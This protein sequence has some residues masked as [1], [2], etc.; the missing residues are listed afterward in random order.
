MKV[1]AQL[2]ISGEGR[3]Q[4]GLQ[5]PGGIEFDLIVSESIVPELRTA[6]H[7]LVARPEDQLSQNGQSDPSDSSEDN[8]SSNEHEHEKQ[9][10]KSDHFSWYRVHSKQKLPEGKSKVI[11]WLAQPNG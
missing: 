7:K 6:L 3:A 11:I 8:S 4:G 1:L 9:N 5:V 10:A 2:K